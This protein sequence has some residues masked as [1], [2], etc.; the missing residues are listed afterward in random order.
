MLGLVISNERALPRVPK[1]TREVVAV[2]ANGQ[3][4]TLQTDPDLSEELSGE[5]ALHEAH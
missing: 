5:S 3:W 1:K 2:E 4:A